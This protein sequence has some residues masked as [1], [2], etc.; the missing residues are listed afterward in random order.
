M[1]ARCRSAL[2][3]FMHRVDEPDSEPGLWDGE[4]KVEQHG[5]L[6]D[7]IADKTI[8][9]IQGYSGRK[10]P[11]LLSVHFNAPHWPWEGP[12][13]E[14]AALKGA[15]RPSKPARSRP[16]DPWCGR[17]ILQ[18][19]GFSARSNTAGSRRIPSW[20][21]PATTA[22]SAFPIPGRLPARRQSCSKAAADPL[23]RASLRR[24]Q[25]DVFERMVDEYAAWEATMLRED[26]VP[27]SYSFNSQQ[28]A[29]HYTPGGGRGA[30]G[31]GGN[32][33][34]PARSGSGTSGTTE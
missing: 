2:D 31:R 8:Q 1:S 20:C 26:L 18:S 13:D 29:D 28:L 9:H 5:Y 16:T 6:T 15:C 17:W 25:S 14:A 34:G 21:S 32:G 22:V 7:L 3:Y 27:G 24:K 4:A 30:A 19:G 12:G 23:E 10:Q 11:F 33:R